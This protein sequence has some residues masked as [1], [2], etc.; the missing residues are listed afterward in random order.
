M[1]KRI[2]E[3]EEIYLKIKKCLNELDTSLDALENMKNDLIKLN[4]YYGSDEWFSDKA[5]YESGK[6]KN[7]KAGV[8]SEDAIWNLLEDLNEIIRRM[9]NFSINQNN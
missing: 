7:V 2:T 9:K 8:L 6:I 3:Y 1:I 4:Q 5:R